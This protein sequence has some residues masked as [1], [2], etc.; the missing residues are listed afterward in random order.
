MKALVIHT[1]R[2]VRESHAE[3]FTSGLTAAL[4][5]RGVETVLLDLAPDA[6]LSEAQEELLNYIFDLTP[7]DMVLWHGNSDPDVLHMV[8]YAMRIL[9]DLSTP[10]S[11]EYHFM[12]ALALIGIPTEAWTGYIKNNMLFSGIIEVFRTGEEDIEVVIEKVTANLEDDI[13]PTEVEND[14]E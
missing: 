2:G 11:V 4:A 10:P 9:A 6:T 12:P 14:C 3:A 5:A 13:E 7:G 8:S 1:W